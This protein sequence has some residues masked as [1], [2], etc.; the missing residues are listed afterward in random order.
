MW[1]FSSKTEEPK[2]PSRDDRQKCWEAR[3]AYFSCLDTVG[4]V[5]AGEERSKGACTSENE[6]YQKNCAQS[7]IEYFNQRRVI[8]EAQK[9]RLAQAS[10]Q[11]Q[12]TTR[13]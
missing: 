9:D 6:T 3:D 10:T 8:A 7:W 13:R 1:P 5:K 4:V 11:A 12:N 2:A